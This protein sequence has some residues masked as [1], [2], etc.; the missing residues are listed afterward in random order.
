[1]VLYYSATGNTEYIARELARRLDDEC[2]NLLSR[3][4][5]H[6]STPINSE[7]PFVICAPII[8]CEM[9]RFLTEWLKKQEYGD[10]SVARILQIAWES[11]R[12]E[13]PETL[14][15]KILHDAHVLEGGRTYLV[16]KTLITGSVRGQSLEETLAYME[17]NVLGKNMCY[18]PETI[19]QCEDMNRYAE[20]FCAAL[21]E[22]IR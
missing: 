22:G 3:I 5:N 12:R 1:M 7:K 14:E 8:V 21:R 9:P 19:A 10:D 17:N 11:Q 15:G 2:V 13:V 4:K 20:D 18:L 16:V 6:D